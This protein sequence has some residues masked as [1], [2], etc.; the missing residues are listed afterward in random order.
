M[1]HHLFKGLLWPLLGITLFLLIWQWGA[2]R[3]H[4]SLGT[5]PGPVATFTQAGQLGQEFL[6]ERER[7][8][9]FLERQA[10]RNAER[11]AADPAARVSQVPY[12]G[13][14]TFVSQVATS[15]LTVLLGF[16]LATLMAVPLG[17]VLGMS[18]RLYQAVNPL[19]QLLKPISPLAWLPLITLVVS[20]LYV[21]KDPAFSK[22]FLISAATVALCSLWPTLI[23]TAVGVGSLDPDLHNVSRVLRLSWW[24][25]VRRLVLPGA[26]PMIFTGLRLSLGVAWMVL[27]AAEMLAQNPGLGKFVWDE[28]QNGG[29]SSLARIMVAVIT[30]GLIGC[31]LD[32]LMLA[33]QQRWSWDKRAALR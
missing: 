15:L 20:A 6:A 30:I 23:N 26:L 2:S 8:Q 19:V 33:L 14:P 1:N 29:A 4:T 22:S 17:I 7:E 31:A 24:T 16:G 12:T 5:L 25:H 27:I 13:R 32:R 21:S 11:L 10:R 9:A 3:V 18:P 28:F